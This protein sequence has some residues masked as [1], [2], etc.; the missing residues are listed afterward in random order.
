MLVQFP[1]HP[2][3]LFGL[4]S[5]CEQLDDEV[6]RDRAAGGFGRVWNA[7]TFK[8]PMQFIVATASA[9]APIHHEL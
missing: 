8:H 1:S 9:N 5:A 3:A 2:W 7:T 6:C 4:A